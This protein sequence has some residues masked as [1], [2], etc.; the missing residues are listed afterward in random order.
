MAAP[1][2]GDTWLLRVACITDDQAAINTYYLIVSGVVGGT[3]L[4]TDAAAAYNTLLAPLYKAVL[5][6]EA[7]Y[8]GVSLGRVLPAPKTVPAKNISARGVGDVAGDMLPGQVSGIIS[9]ATA[10]AGRKF[11]GRVFIPFPSETDNAAHIPVAGYGTRLQALATAMLAPL[12]VTAGASSATFTPF[13]FHRNDGSST[14]ITTMLAKRLWATQRRRG[15][16]GQR[17]PPPF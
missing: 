9:F 11:R 3:V 17:N 13:L 12:T 16:F 7:E 10:F 2:D 4:D 15:D 5:S 8:Y 1:V 6:E 14:K